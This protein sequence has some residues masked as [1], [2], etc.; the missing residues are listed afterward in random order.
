VVGEKAH[1][2]DKATLNSEKNLAC[3]YIAIIE[4][5]ALV[6]QLVSWSVG[7][8]IGRS[9]SHDQPVSKILLNKKFL[10]ISNQLCKRVYG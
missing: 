5:C 9:V 3:S 4:L 7:G 2:P 6:S 1:S 8:S 10:K